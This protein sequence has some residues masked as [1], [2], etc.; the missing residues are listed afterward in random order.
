MNGTNTGRRRTMREKH[1]P[2]GTVR[3]KYQFNHKM[4]D[5]E[6]K[7][8]NHIIIVTYVIFPEWEA[9]ISFV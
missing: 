4:R 8:S 7:N 6:E 1:T 3:T 2:E 5:R 9:L